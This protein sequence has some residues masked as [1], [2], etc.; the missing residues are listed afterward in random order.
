MTATQTETGTSTIT[1]TATETAIVTVATCYEFLGYYDYQNVQSGFPKGFK[2]DSAGFLYFADSGSSQVRKIKSDGTLVWDSGKFTTQW[3]GVQYSSGSGD[4]EFTGPKDVAV[5]NGYVYVAD[6]GNNRI[7]I[8]NASTGAYVGQFGSY[9]SGDMQFNNPT[10]ISTDSNGDI[11]VF[12]AGNMRIVKILKTNT[13]TF[14]WVL[15]ST[16]SGYADLTNIQTFTIGADDNLYIVACIFP[17]GTGIA[18]SNWLWIVKGDRSL[19]RRAGDNT[20]AFVGNLTVTVDSQTAYVATQNSVLAINLVTGGFANVV[21]TVSAGNGIYLLSEGRVVVWLWV[22]GIDGRFCIYGVCG[23]FPTPTPT[24]TFTPAPTDTSMPTASETETPLTGL[25][26]TETPTGTA[27]PSATNTE[28]L[29]VTATETP[30]STTDTS[31]LFAN[32]QLSKVASHPNPNNDGT[33]K[34]SFK[35]DGSTSTNVIQGLIGGGSA[36]S[37]VKFSNSISPV[38]LRLYMRTG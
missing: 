30:T 8:L 5:A 22:G 15:D 25:T 10:A 7:Q 4:G 11:Y 34:R 20:Y 19:V 14:N 18:L 1:A 35:I 9:G 24:I 2:V 32:A 6:S 17:T 37:G 13:T 16:V 28:T 27:T 12:D 36:W 26:D 33:S 38:T 21:T 23:K 3:W 31:T 29:Q